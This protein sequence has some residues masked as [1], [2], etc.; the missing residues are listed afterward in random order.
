MNT[1]EFMEELGADWLAPVRPRP[2]TGPRKKLATLLNAR[3]DL[4][5]NWKQGDYRAKISQY[6]LLNRQLIFVNTPEG[7][8]RILST[9]HDNY[10]RKS[11]QMR[12]A[13]EFLIGDGLFISDGETWRGRRPLVADL[14]AKS[15]L[16][17]FGRTIASA[18]QET[19]DEWKGI[20]PE[21]PID[22]LSEMGV[23]TAEIISRALFGVRL[24]RAL[25]I[26][27]TSS[28]ADYQNQIDSFNVGYL[29]GFDEGLPVWRGLKLRRATRQVHAVIDHVI[30]DQGDG[31]YDGEIKPKIVAAKDLHRSN[32]LTGQVVVRE[33]AAT[34]FM[35]GH[36]TT[37]ATLAWV[38]Y[39]LSK[40]PW[41]EAAVHAE[42]AAVCG[43]RPPSYED[44]SNLVYCRAVVEETLRLYPPVAMLG[45]Q[46]RD[47]DDL[48]AI[49]VE[50][51]A[52]IIISPWLLHRSPDL[53]LFP[54]RFMPERF[55]G[56]GR[57]ATYAYIPFAIGPRVCPGMGFGLAESVLCLATLAQHYRLRLAP[58]ASVL[59]QCRLTLR[60]KGG[61]PMLVERR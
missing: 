24:G 39:L 6:R 9:R 49:Q 34:L 2:R 51:A 59:P 10:E 22:V 14:L 57:P 17:D 11:P 40:A 29:L 55:I 18:A 1:S 41:A 33:E 45:R 48:G 23:L 46:A 37:A 3:R 47:A 25:S 44:L 20:D 54:D 27:V 32:G 36:E 60:P 28:F 21:R 19:V 5:I 8:K 38:W 35:A 15:R 42:I 30:A 13:L 4:L 12:R 52:L 58:G 43:L 31:L 56:E 7:V 16:S 50:R 26:Q 53:W 61:L